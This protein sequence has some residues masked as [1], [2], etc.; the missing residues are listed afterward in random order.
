MLL[1]GP[2]ELVSIA[3]RTALSEIARL[4]DRYSRYRPDSLLTTINEAASKGRSIELDEE[5]SGLLDYALACYELSG[6][7]FD[8]TSGILR[9]AWDFPIKVLPAQSEIDLLLERVGLRH[10]DWKRPRLGFPVPG[11]ELDFGGIVKEYAVDRCIDLW[12]ALGV[13]HGLIGMAGDIATLGSQ[14][15]GTPWIIGVADP[16]GGNSVVTSVA[17]EGQAI[18]TSGNYARCFTE[19]GQ[20]YSHLLN[21]TT[22]WPVIGLSSVTVIAP[23]CLAAGSVA[24][25]AMLK[26][27]DGPEWLGATE[28]SH[29][30]IDDSGERGGELFKR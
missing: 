2:G 9:Q 10:L 8:I 29:G 7:L 26:G 1:S 27:V 21:P 13:Q 5:T 22:G 6:G 28:F 19:D 25:I 15:D 23:K 24:T 16:N 14:P 4:E 3:H 18:A 20:I 12:S 11:I 30:W 17:L